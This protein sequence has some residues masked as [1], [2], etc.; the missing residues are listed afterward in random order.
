MKTTKTINIIATIILFLVLSSCIPTKRAYV[1]PKQKKTSLAIVKGINSTKVKEATR[2][3]RAD[4]ISLFPLIDKIHF[5]SQYN[6]CV[7]LPENHTFEMALFQKNGDVEMLVGDYLVNFDAE[8]GKTYVIGARIE[9]LTS[10]V[11]VYVTE[12]KSGKRVPSTVE[13]KYKLK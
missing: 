6:R 8:A 4:T 13:Y 12:E 2:L 9:P 7:V 10:I 3:L 11:D 1:G 5:S